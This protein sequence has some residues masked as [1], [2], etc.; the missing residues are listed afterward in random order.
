MLSQ[1]P[2]ISA[3]TA[4]TILAPFAT[5]ADFLTALRADASFLADVKVDWGGKK[6]KLSAPIAEKLV[7][8][9]CVD[10]AKP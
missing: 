6:R 7:D 5:F 4:A 1:I 10:A 2:G 9:F 8:Y 3:S